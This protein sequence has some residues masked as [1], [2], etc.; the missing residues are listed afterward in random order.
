MSV[1]LGLNASNEEMG[2]K[3]QN[4]WAFTEN[5]IQ[6][7]EN[8]SQL[9]VE[10]MLDAT[11]IPLLFISFPSAK[12]PNWTL[13]PGRKDKS[14]VAIITLARWE[15]YEKWQDNPLKRRGDDYKAVMNNTLFI[16]CKVHFL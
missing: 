12:D 7:Y 1:F 11:K 13:H 8:Y 5:A 4:V 3:S 2:L 9:D 14:T 10:G 6:D 15:W 16:C